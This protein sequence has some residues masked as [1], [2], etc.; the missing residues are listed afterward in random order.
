MALT[1]KQQQFVVEYLIDAN[2]AQAAIR[3]GYSERTAKEQ[4][5]RLLTKDS[6][7]N[8]L[9]T[10]R[11]RLAERAELTAQMIVDEL[12]NLA[13]ANMKDFFDDNDELKPMSALTRDQAAAIAECTTT[14]IVITRGEQSTVV[15]RK[16]KLKLV[17]KRESLVDLGKHLGL[18][19]GEDAAP[20][21]VTFIVN[22]APRREG[23]RLR[24]AG[25]DTIEGELVEGD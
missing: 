1:P 8:A 16:T 6:V 17:N 13:F 14:D 3:A 21:H 20:P 5:S 24:S 10:M 25:G 9:A 15:S 2:G 7:Q 19:S 22:Y 11:S 4:A 18:W 23:P 12:R